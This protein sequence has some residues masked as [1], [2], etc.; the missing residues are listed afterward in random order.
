MK[1]KPKPKKADTATDRVTA[2]ADLRQLPGVG[3]KTAEDLWELGLRSASD[4]RGQD[5]E[6]L[7]QKLC[8]L[9]GAK[10]D[11]CMLYVFRCAV[12]YASHQ[13]HQPELLKWWNWKDGGE[14]MIKWGWNVANGHANEKT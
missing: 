13:Q 6:A 14:T 2:L 8:R 5:P 12:Y 4:L 1:K 7:Y 3:R 11:R 10:I 9:Q